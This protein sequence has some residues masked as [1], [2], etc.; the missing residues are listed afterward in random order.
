MNGTALCLHDDW[1]QARELELFTDASGTIGYGAYWSG[2][3]P[4]QEHRLAIAIGMVAA[5]YNFNVV[6]RHILHC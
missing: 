3:L 6:V 5:H 4:H 1:V 2:Q